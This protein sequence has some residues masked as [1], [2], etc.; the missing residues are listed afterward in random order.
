MLA[1]RP[2]CCGAVPLGVRLVCPGCSL[3]RPARSSGEFCEVEGVGQ[4][5]KAPPAPEAQNPVA[6]F[7]NSLAPSRTWARWTMTDP[8]RECSRHLCT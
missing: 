3:P 6:A 7:F 2:S 4:E 1:L 5:V 8:R